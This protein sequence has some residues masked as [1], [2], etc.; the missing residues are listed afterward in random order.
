MLEGKTRDI[1]TMQSGLNREI[2]FVKMQ[3][4]DG[5]IAIV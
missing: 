4:K 2:L 3:Q 1:I 5:I